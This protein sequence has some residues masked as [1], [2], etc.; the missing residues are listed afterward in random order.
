M[1]SKIPHVW[2]LLVDLVASD[3]C[4]QMWD[5]YVDS[6]AWF[7]GSGSAGST[8]SP[9]PRANMT[10]LMASMSPSESSPDGTD[11]GFQKIRGHS[12]RRLDDLAGVAIDL[13]SETGGDCDS[14]QIAI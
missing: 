3:E 4:G 7:W 11:E 2:H 12:H 8:T 9:K 13:G 5:W 6:Q 10:V 1:Q 14:G